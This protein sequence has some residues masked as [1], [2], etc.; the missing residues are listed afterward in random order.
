METVGA[1]SRGPEAQPTIARATA[2]I[3]LNVRRRLIGAV[4]TYPFIYLMVFGS[5]ASWSASA[6]ILNAISSTKSM[7]DAT[8]KLVN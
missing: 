4:I 6:N 7:T 8:M 2:A 1:V 3:R 5:S